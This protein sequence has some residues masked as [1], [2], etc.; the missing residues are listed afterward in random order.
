M[1]TRGQ[2]IPS[3]PGN[4]LLNRDSIPIAFAGGD[5]VKAPTTAYSIL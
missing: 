3:L 4:R 2:R 1:P 5:A